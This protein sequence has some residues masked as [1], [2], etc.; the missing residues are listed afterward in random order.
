MADG[1]A[2]RSVFGPQGAP[3]KPAVHWKRRLDFKPHN[4]E[5]PGGVDRILCE[6]KRRI[7]CGFQSLNG[8]GYQEDFP[9]SDFLN[10][11]L[12]GMSLLA[13][14]AEYQDLSEREALGLEI[15]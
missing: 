7:V 4:F 13:S 6:T 15:L 5:R 10:G 8:A 2:P 9:A 12:L 3:S 14:W 11:M 1:T